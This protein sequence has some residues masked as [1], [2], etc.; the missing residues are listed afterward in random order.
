MDFSA[1]GYQPEYLLARLQ[2]LQRFG[3]LAQICPGIGGY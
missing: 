2:K 1:P 3:S